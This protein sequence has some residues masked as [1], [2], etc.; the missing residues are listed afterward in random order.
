MF[1]PILRERKSVYYYILAW[2]LI[3]AIHAGILFF[4]YKSELLFAVIDAIIFNSIF[5]FLGIVLWYPV[6]YIK[7]EQRYPVLLIV[8]HIVVA[9]L[10]ITLWLSAGYFILESFIIDNQD[11]LDFLTQSIPWRFASGVLI[12]TVIILIYYLIIYYTDLKEKVKAEAELKALVKE[13]ELTLL[14]SQ[15]NPHFLFNSLNSISS[16]TVSKPTKAQEMV[17]KLSEFL[18]YALKHDQKTKTTLKEELYNIELYLDIEKIRFGEKLKFKK[19]IEKN[20]DKLFLPNLILQPL[21]ENA[22]KHG[23]Y[24]SAEQI[25][26]SLD[27]SVSKNFME[28]VIQ[29]NFDPEYISKRING[30]GLRN[31]KNRLILIYNRE[32]L[33]LFGKKENVFKVKLLI[34]IMK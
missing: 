2:I 22:I 34:P 10:S 13:S 12:Y 16:L 30:L 19:K 28:I 32:D 20:C 24:P 18:R 27:C 1:N 7:N 14:R 11:Y 21:I 9:F 17:V 6:R 33:F 15:I 4:F 3:T 25:I 8:N 31:I 26:I 5:G 23:V 29:N